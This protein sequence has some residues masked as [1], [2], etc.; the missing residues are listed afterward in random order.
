MSSTATTIL[1]AEDARR[2]V[3]TQA[4]CSTCKVLIPHDTDHLL[5]KP[6][7]CV[8]CPPLFT[9][10]GC[11]PEGL[12]WLPIYSDPGW[13]LDSTDPIFFSKV[14]TFV[15]IDLILMSIARDATAV[16]ARVSKGYLFEWDKAYDNITTAIMFGKF[17]DAVTW[18]HRLK[19]LEEQT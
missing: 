18:R 13:L 12:E 2:L 15:V 19:D 14:H 17:E 11:Q 3:Q 6:D 16:Y 10:C 8:A 1:S 5:G 4:W 9:R 7:L